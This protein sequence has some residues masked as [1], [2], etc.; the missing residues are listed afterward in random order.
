MD[1]NLLEQAWNKQT[2]AAPAVPIAPVIA[3]LEIEVR[4]AQRRFHGAMVIAV[5]LLLLGWTMTIAAHLG[6]IKTLTPLTLVS[7]VVGSALYTALLLRAKQSARATRLEIAHLGGTLRES[8]TATLRTIELQIQNASIAAVAIPIVVAVSGWLFLA[9]YFAGEMPGFGAVFGSGFVAVLGA[10]IG[11][12]FWHR[13]RTVLAPRRREL[14]A[15][16]SALE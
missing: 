10:M 16:L 9:K 7:Q 2:V 1:L 12:A 5:S 14:S 3:R 8:M 15:T 11:G 13:Y 4:S 6:G